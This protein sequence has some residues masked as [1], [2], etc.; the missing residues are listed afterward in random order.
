MA[1]MILAT[2]GWGGWWVTFLLLRLAPG[3]APSPGYAMWWGAI[4]GAC[5]LVAAFLSIRARL[6]WV[7]FATIALFANGT[8]ILAPILD[9]DLVLLEAVQA[10][11]QAP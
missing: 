7:L 1:A 5:G 6:V 3:L 9:A 2:L 10:G 4:L 8:L 11:E